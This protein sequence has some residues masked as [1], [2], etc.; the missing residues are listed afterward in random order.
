MK[1]QR[2]VF[3]HRSGSKERVIPGSTIPISQV[4][5]KVAICLKEEEMKW[6]RGKREG[7][8]RQ[9]EEQEEIKD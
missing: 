8:R 1:A 7:K 9:E 4:L 2:L 6:R 3:P 5:I